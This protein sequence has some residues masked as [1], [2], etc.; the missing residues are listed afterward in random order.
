MHCLCS[1]K[2]DGIL[3]G[4]NSNF[5]AL[6]PKVP[7]AWFHYQLEAHYSCKFHFQ[8][9][10][11]ILSERWAPIPA[12][13]I[14]YNQTAFVKGTNMHQYIGLTSKCSWITNV[15][16]EMWHSYEIHLSFCYLELG[17]LFSDLTKYVFN[18]T[19][20]KGICTLTDDYCNAS[21]KCLKNVLKLLNSYG[22]VSGQIRTQ[23]MLGSGLSIEDIYHFSFRDNARFLT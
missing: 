16:V 17:V 8:D 13:I 15:L 18:A 4:F 20:W 19:F 2:K 22:D 10:P 11:K 12:R 21:Q 14:S 7:I 23:C 3:L 6:I 5:I 1:S 9:H